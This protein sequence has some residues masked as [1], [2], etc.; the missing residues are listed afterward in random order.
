MIRTALT[1]TEATAALTGY[2]YDSADVNII[3]SD[4]TMSPA[5][6]RG[7]VRS[8]SMNPAGYF[9]ITPRVLGAQR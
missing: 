9:F 2:G 7:A 3:I 6:P 1:R 4:A 8:V 5:F